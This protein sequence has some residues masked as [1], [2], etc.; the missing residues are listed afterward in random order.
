MMAD[1][2][3]NS[4]ENHTKRRSLA[5][6]LLRATI[7]SAFSLQKKIPFAQS[8]LYWPN[9]SRISLQFSSVYV[10]MNVPLVAA[11]TC[12]L[13]FAA[14]SK[15][16]ENECDPMKMAGTAN[17]AANCCI[18]K[19]NKNCTTCNGTRYATCILCEKKSHFN[20]Q[21]VCVYTIQFP[22]VKPNGYECICTRARKTIFFF[23]HSSCFVR[24][25]I[26]LFL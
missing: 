8:V 20:G 4:Q 1:L 5:S 13:R 2:F 23:F 15:V 12:I 14:Y 25:K 18:C 6:L 24:N 7:Y 19:G 21:I 3:A 26:V 9:I 11:I 16:A 10:Q 22:T 17:A